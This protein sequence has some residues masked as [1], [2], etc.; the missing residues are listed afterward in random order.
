MTEQEKV[1]TK[2]QKAL[3]AL[4]RMMGR[5]EG[6]AQGRYHGYLAGTI[7]FHPIKWE[8][9]EH[10]YSDARITAYQ[11]AYPKAVEEAEMDAEIVKGGA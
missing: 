8:D 2:Q 1:Q 9:L 3:L 5:L 11:V 7:K 6:G 10:A 4:A